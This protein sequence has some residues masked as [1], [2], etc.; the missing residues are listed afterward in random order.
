MS[1]EASVT[2]AARTRRGVVASD[3]MMKTI[4]VEVTR[5]FRHPKYKRFVKQHLRYSAHDPEN[6]CRMGDVVVIEETRPLSKSKRWRLKEV[7]ER[8]PVI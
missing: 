2:V 1:G 8:A 3:K 7:V 4:I 5:R 6:T